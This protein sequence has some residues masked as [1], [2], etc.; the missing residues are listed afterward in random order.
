VNKFKAGDIAVE[1]PK[2]LYEFI[3][4]FDKQ[5]QY[6]SPHYYISW[7]GLLKGMS[8][9]YMDAESE[10]AKCELITDIFRNI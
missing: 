1:N 8:N 2:N 10:D 6:K 7:V 4:Y 3:C 5:T 9:I